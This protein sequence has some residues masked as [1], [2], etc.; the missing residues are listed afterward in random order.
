MPER[1]AFLKLRLSTIVSRCS[2]PQFLG[3]SQN[4]GHSH[5]CHG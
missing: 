1:I 3:L 5:G 4:Q 2:G